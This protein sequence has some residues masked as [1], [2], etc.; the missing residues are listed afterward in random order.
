MSNFR[1]ACRGLAV[2][3]ANAL[4]PHDCCVCG[5]LAVGAPVCAACRAELPR[6]SAAER[7]P[8]CAL[9]MP[10]G[11]LCGRCQRRPPAFDATHAVFDYR[12]P[13]DALIR[14]LKY[15]HRLALATFFAGELTAA[16]VPERAGFIV[17]MPLH[18]RRLGERGFNQAV[19]I[20]RPLARKT[21]LR[22]ELAAVRRV[23]DTPQQETLTREERVRN[24][25]GAFACEA[26]LDGA[27]V[28][29]VDDVMTSG[30]SLNELARCLKRSGA[31]RVENLVVARTPMPGQATVRASPRP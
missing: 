25:R 5:A 17:P 1:A 21:G 3:A 31:A 22:L 28:V 16:G 6:M 11:S 8:L 14:A 26:A 2:R 27:T 23:R 12:F 7:C 9:P 15:R 18:P 10:D 13:V 24:L 30:A 20:A 19:E 29:V 4:L